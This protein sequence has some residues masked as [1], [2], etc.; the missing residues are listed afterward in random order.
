MD[1]YC[2]QKFWWLGVDIEKQETTSCCTA[3]ADRIDID[4]LTS[5][6]GQLFNT[7]KLKTER[8]LL[9]DNNRPSS[10]TV[11]WQAEDR[12]IPSRRQLSNSQIKTHT[13]LNSTPSSLN[14]IIGS[15][16]N[17]TCSYCCKQFSSAWS[18]DLVVNGEYQVDEPNRYSMTQKDKVIYKLSQKEMMRSKTRS[19]LLDE[20]ALLPAEKIMITGG[21]PFLNLDLSDLVSKA[22]CSESLEIWTGLGVNTHRLVNEIEKIKTTPNIRIVISAENIESYYEFNRYG[23]S[24]EKFLSNLEVIKQSG[25]PFYFAATVS[26]IT[27]FGLSEFISTFGDHK[28]VFNTCNDPE[29]LSI[30]VLDDDSKLRLTELL[31]NSKA[32]IPDIIKGINAPCSQKQKQQAAVFIKEFARRRNLSLSIFPESFI[33]W[34]NE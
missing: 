27:L 4:W 23:N 25:I 3:T 6:S 11:C 24:Y 33:N 26:N 9:L 19:A 1:N 15:D 10:C 32:K 28:I 8:Q 7:T 18:T 31:T 13:N 5:N 14:I 12:G 30:N 16:C 2:S 22:V 21:E 17:L 29:F 34:I 20:I